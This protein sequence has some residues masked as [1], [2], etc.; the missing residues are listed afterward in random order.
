MKEQK[1]K[2]SDDNNVYD[3]TTIERE[4]C[5]RII[6]NNK[7]I[8][9]LIKRVIKRIEAILKEQSKKFKKDIP[10]AIKGEKFIGMTYKQYND[11]KKQNY[12]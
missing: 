3:W 4:K 10:K 2:D 11:I 7:I 6:Y 1:I 5:F 9:L 8:D 12:Q